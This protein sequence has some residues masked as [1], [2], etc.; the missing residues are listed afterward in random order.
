MY[1]ST[2]KT[3][4]SRLVSALLFQRHASTLSNSG[5]ADARD[6]DPRPYIPPVARGSKIGKSPALLGLGPFLSN[7]Y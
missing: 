5:S 2:H 7:P 6:E 3:L 4:V 1:I